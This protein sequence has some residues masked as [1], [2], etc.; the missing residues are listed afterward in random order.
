M[1][2]GSPKDHAH[3]M[4]IVRHPDDLNTI[5]VA[6]WHS[7]VFKSTDGGASWNRINTGLTTR[8]VNVLTITDDGK[9]LYAATQ[10]EGVF[11]MR[12]F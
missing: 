11:R 1:I 4:S 6:D 5:F 3:V 8:A 9:W 7:G 2:S 10:G 12:N